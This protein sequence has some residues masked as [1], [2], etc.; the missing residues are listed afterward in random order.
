MRIRYAYKLELED[1]TTTFVVLSHIK[2][3]AEV[4]EQFADKGCI[5][6]VFHERV[7]TGYRLNE[8]GD[9]VPTGLTRKAPEEVATPAAAEEPTV[10]QP[11]AKKSSK[12]AKAE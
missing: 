10:K 7:R 5:S 6:A 1:G 4:Q 12:K 9:L 3:E 11:K 8:E 2:S